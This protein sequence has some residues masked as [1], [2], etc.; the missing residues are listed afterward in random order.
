MF[1]DWLGPRWVSLFFYSALVCR[2]SLRMGGLRVE[3]QEVVY[4]GGFVLAVW[5][6]LGAMMASLAPCS[7]QALFDEM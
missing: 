6:F 7:D 1:I 2:W 5:H 4:I 3:I